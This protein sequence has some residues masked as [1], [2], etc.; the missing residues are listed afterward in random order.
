MLVLFQCTCFSFKRLTDIDLVSDGGCRRALLDTLSSRRGALMPAGGPAHP[1]PPRK[2][3]PFFTLVNPFLD[4]PHAHPHWVA[5]ERTY[6]KAPTTTCC[7]V[8]RSPT[9]R[10]NTTLALQRKACGCCWGTHE[11]P[12]VGAHV[13]FVKRTP[14]SA[15]HADQLL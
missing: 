13:S 8:P 2:C 9:V 5:V 11:V 1:P 12:P 3:Q 6:N 4:A 7:V 10:G 15:H 14:A